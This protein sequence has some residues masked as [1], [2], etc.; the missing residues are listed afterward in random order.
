MAKTNKL[1]FVTLASGNVVGYKNLL[2]YS[3]Q[4]DYLQRFLQNLP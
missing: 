1:V 3:A 4:R 2:F